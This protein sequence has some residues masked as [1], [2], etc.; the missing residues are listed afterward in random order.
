MTTR[1]PELVVSRCMPVDI[2]PDSRRQEVIGAPTISAAHS[3]APAGGRARRRCFSS[4]KGVSGTAG[5]C[6]CRSVTIAI[7]DVLHAAQVLDGVT[8]RTPV[9]RSDELDELVGASVVLKAES[10]QRGG[11]FKLRGAFTKISS[12]PE[13]ERRLGVVAVSSG[14]HAIAVALSARLLGTTAVILVPEDA[15]AA[16][17]DVARGLG[18]ELVRFDRFA[19]DRDA[20]TSTL[21]AERGL[22]FVPPYDDPVIVA[23]Q[24]TVALE[25]FDD[26]GTLDALLVPVSGGGLMAGC[27]VVAAERAPA[28]RMIGV[29]PAVMD[30][31][32]R[33]LAAGERV[34]VPISP[35]LADGLTVATPG[36]VT[37]E[38]NR[39][40]L[41]EVVTVTDEQLVD[42]M[43]V[44]FRL[45]HLVVEP[46]GA[47]GLAALLAGAV[48]VR[49]QR[50]GVVLSGGNIGLDRFTEL[51]GV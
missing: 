9:V 33:S 8:V 43:R 36:A 27:S 12:I 39:R 44:A 30:D 50:V 22:P 34:A 26:A 40:R 21:V 49:E 23:G 6:H 20:V 29:E 31:T 42:A 7:A 48:D 46:S 37:W 35:T 4:S 24:G 51:V 17:V 28:C 5:V 25:L 18:A 1:S 32:R 14:N 3:S 15:P 41:S 47:A 16:K 2:P 13:D 10:L 38:I 45:L 19:D 11:A